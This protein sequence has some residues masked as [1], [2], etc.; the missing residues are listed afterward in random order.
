MT[1][2]ISFEMEDVDYQN[3]IMIL[4]EHISNQYM[5]LVSPDFNEAEKDWIK[6]NQKYVETNIINPIIKG[7]TK[8]KKIEEFQGD[9]RFLSNFYPSPFEYEGKQW[10][11][12]EHAFQALKSLSVDEQETIRNLSSPSEA[13]KAGKQV[14]LRTD[15]EDVKI[16]LMRS[17]V[18][19]KFL[20]NE[21]LKNKLL[22]TEDA[23]LEEGNNW[24]DVTYGIC[25]PGSGNGQNKLGK[26]LM[27]IRSKI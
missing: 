23:I 27:E 9:Y 22:E 3:L 8:M 1:V 4:Q 2:K 17:L 7:Y 26:I 25:P 18:Y 20:Q 11:T 16:P 13:K 19:Q 12:V 24:N 5:K 14:N 6:R 15:W 21:N 10:P